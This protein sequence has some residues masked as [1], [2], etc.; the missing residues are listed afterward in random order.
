M[1]ATDFR[2]AFVNLRKPRAKG[3]GGA[4]KPAIDDI[5]RAS[6]TLAQNGCCRT[7]KIAESAER[8]REQPG[9]SA[10]RWKMPGQRVG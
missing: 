5:E 10:Q 2:V 1:A 8:L 6:M 3:L 9:A 4:F 7:A